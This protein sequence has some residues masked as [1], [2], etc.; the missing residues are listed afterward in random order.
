MPIDTLGYQAPARPEIWVAAIGIPQT[1][2]EGEQYTIEIVAGS[3][4]AATA[5]LT[6][7][8]GAAQ[9]AAQ[10]VQL[11]PGENR[12][13]FRARAGQPG[14][15]R[16]SASLDGGPDTFPQNNHGAAT[17]LVAPQPRVLLVESQPGTSPPRRS[18]PPRCRHGSRTWRR[19]RASCCSTCRPAT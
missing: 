1:L 13:T 17:A 7:G 19:S 9:L 18:P 6:L 12:L 11:T 10:D 8:D 5:R 3:S 2:R 14:I 16:L 4:E 15:L